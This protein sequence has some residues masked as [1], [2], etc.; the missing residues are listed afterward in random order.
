[1]LKEQGKLE[2]AEALFRRALE[3]REA[4]LGA[5]HKDTLRS[6]NNLAGVLQDQG[7]LEE[8]EA[9][10]RRAL[11]EFEATLGATHERTVNSRGNL[12]SV[13]MQRPGQQEEGT[14]MVRDALAALSAPPHSLPASHRWMI[15]F[16]ALLA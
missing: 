1:M 15:K 14:A 9:L 11:E 7:K 2:E 16:S 8:S 6:T 5:S 12:G 10:F 3:G 4:T 13:L